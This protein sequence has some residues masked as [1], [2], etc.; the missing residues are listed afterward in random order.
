MGGSSHI[1]T[2]HSH[3]HSHSPGRHSHSPGHHSSCCNGTSCWEWKIQLRSRFTVS[4]VWMLTSVPGLLYTI[5]GGWSKPHAGVSLIFYIHLHTFRIYDS[6]GRKTSSELRILCWCDR[7]PTIKADDFAKQ[8][9][10][11]LECPVYCVFVSLRSMT[12]LYR[13]H[14]FLMPLV[15]IIFVIILFIW[16]WNVWLGFMNIC[17]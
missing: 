16:Q 6:L 9:L 5:L 14:I 4:S 11:C 8:T 2:H 15:S 1:H 13:K 12:S 3:G 7:S 10:L 17:T